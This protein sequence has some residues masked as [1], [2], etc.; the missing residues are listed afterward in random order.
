M[1]QSLWN[2]AVSSPLFRRRK[3]SNK[4]HVPSTVLEGKA[5]CK[6]SRERLA[7]QNQTGHEERDK[8]LAYFFREREISAEYIV[9]E[10]ISFQTSFIRMSE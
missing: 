5:P 8:I 6:H 2:V 10:Y 3:F 4:L 7:V 9:G 1:L